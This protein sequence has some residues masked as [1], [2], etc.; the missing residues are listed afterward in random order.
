MESLT[1]RS[2]GT[3]LFVA[4]LKVYYFFALHMTKI[5][6]LLAKPLQEVPEVELGPAQWKQFSKLL[7]RP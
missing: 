6:W 4:V 7:K 2:S 1:L 3:R 5:N